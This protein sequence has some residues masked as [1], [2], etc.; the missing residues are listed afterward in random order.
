MKKNS[1]LVAL[2]LVSLLMTMFV[3]GCELDVDPDTLN[4]KNT[5]G[6]ATAYAS[7]TSD[8]VS[9]ISDFS[10]FNNFK[11]WHEDQYIDAELHQVEDENGGKIYI[12]KMN[13]G[14]LVNLVKHEVEDVFEAYVEVYV[15]CDAGGFPPYIIR[16]INP[17]NNGNVE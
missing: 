13:R 15:T 12:L 4:V 16:V 1:L 17:D 9:W 5:K 2:V 10:G 14:D 8:D 3:T 7:L 11:V 6:V